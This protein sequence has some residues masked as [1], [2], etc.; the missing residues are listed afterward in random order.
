MPFWQKSKQVAKLCRSQARFRMPAEAMNEAMEFADADGLL[1]Y[2]NPRFCEMLA[3]KADDV[4][5]RKFVDLLDPANR[6]RWLEQQ[7]KRKQGIA[8]SYGLQLERKD[9]KGAGEIYCIA[10][11]GPLLND[12]GQFVGSIG[13]LIDITE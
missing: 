13:V 4:V 3:V 1:T 9:G 2:A 11:G 12:D 5:G 8:T 6:K 7:E 10:S